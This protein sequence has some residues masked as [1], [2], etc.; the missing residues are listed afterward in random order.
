MHLHT[1]ADRL[2]RLLQPWEICVK[3][4]TTARRRKS[5][6]RPDSG[7]SHISDRTLLCGVVQPPEDQRGYLIRL[8]PGRTGS[9]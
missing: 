6:S 7:E 4:P 3:V 2:S 5:V 1:G 8:A 9:E